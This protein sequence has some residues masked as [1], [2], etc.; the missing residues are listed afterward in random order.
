VQFEID[1]SGIL[2]VLARDIQTGKET[3]ADEISGGCG[4]RGGPTNG[5]GI[6]RARLEDLAARR[7]IEAKLKAKELV[8]NPQRAGDCRQELETIYVE[9][10]RLAVRAVEAA[11]DKADTDDPAPNLSEFESASAELDEITKPMAELLMDRAMEALLRKKGFCRRTKR[12]T[13]PPPFAV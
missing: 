5:R 6:G 12:R 10:W 8:S 7:W 9:R 11:L 3:G 2:H 13:R 1:A 4:R